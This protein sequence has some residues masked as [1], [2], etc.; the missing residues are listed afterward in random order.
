[1]QTQLQ[2]LSDDE[3]SLV[4]ELTLNLLS[5]SGLRVD[6][7]GGRNILSEAGAQVDELTSMVRLPRA[8]IE[9]ALKAAPRQFRLGGR[10]PGWSFPV[11]QGDCT[12]LAD[13]GAVF[14]FDFQSN[15]NRLATF[16]DWQKATR[17]IDT[18]DEVGIYWAMVQ[19]TFAEGSFG[20]LVAY[21]GNIFRNFSKHVQDCPY[22]P[23][24]SRWMLEVLQVIF[25]GKE[26]V[27]RFKPVSFLLNPLSPLVIEAAPTDAYLE[28]LG[29]DIPVAVMPMPMM[30]STAPASLLSTLVQA[31]CEVLAMLCLIQAAAPGTPVL[32]APAPTVMELHSGRFAGG[33]IEHA[34]L[35]AAV[36]EM[37]RFY[38]LP[39]QASTGGSGSP[40]PGLQAGYERALNWALPALSWPD[41]LVGPGLLGG[42]LSLCLEQLL[43]D[44]EV[45]RRCRR[46]H[47][48]VSRADAKG[49]VEE[50]QT[51][52]PGADFLA[53]RSTRDAVRKGEWYISKVGVNTSL[54]GWQANDR[55]EL[56]PSL[57]E[58]I[59][60]ILA[61]YQPLELDETVEQ[62]LASLEKRAR[63]NNQVG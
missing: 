56:L 49:L 8:L 44:V 46:L 37:G 11:N 47:C 21:W 13:G 9:S 23:E 45:F 19:P 2:V 32:Y 14:T 63:E 25:N 26:A 50:I 16:E 5:T 1:M 55:P 35:G 43:I 31:N 18:L 27:Q 12:L 15:Q 20:N 52:G 28:T 51:I 48:G 38:G 17:L 3:R 22:T 7:P 61:A 34:L 54:E 29:W 57:R 59:S 39:V 58:E 40:I 62:E 10:L 24:G 42:S 33:E 53:Q 36:T 60:H 30:G 4:H 41:I 6:T